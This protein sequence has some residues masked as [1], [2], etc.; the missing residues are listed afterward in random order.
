[1]AGRRNLVLG[2]LVGGFIFLFLLFFVIGIVSMMGR[3]DGWSG[4][5]DKLAIVE[6]EGT[7][8]E[9]EQAVSNLR[10][11]ADN[12]SVKG[13]LVRINSPGG[14]VA[15]SQ[16]IYDEILR[17]RDDGLPVVVSMGSVAASGGYYIACAGDRV[18]ANP[19]TLTGSIGVILQYP[20]VKELMDKIGIQYQTIKTGR[21]KD[22]GS[23]FREPDQADIEML[24]AAMEDVHAQFVNVV[25]ERRE[26]DPDSVRTLAD[27][28]IFTGRQA[29]ELGLVDEL[30]S[31]EDALEY[32]A[33]IADLDGDFSRLKPRERSE[34]T[35]FDLLGEAA[36]DYLD[37]I[38]T[39]GPQ[40]MYLYR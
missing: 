40:L 24:S 29:M 19:G 33:D 21:V 15:P 25:A 5:G 16:E 14:V 18:F 38:R 27:G 35:I 1:M 11:Y 28:S 34:L 13:I 3:E 26:L 39:G 31:Y 9:S 32:L 22:V 4:F 12:S 7:I 36:L 23:P 2:I 6:I 20:V 30:G 8:L 37:E 17:I 10:E